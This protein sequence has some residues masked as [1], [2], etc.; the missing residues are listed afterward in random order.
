[1]ILSS[2]S[3]RFEILRFRRLQQA[4]GPKGEVVTKRLHIYQGSLFAQVIMDIFGVGI[5]CV[6]CHAILDV[7]AKG[8]T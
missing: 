3:D 2:P 8:L 1:M 7:L 5:T 4:E 6:T